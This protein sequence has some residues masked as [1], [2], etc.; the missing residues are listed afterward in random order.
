MPQ[1]CAIAQMAGY[2][3]GDGNWFRKELQGGSFGS[4]D[5]GRA[6]AGCDAAF[7]VG[8]AGFGGG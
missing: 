3:K 7:A 6:A 1:I 2:D 4:D 5:A 8:R